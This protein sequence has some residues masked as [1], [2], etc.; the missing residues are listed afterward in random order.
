[1]F[2]TGTAMLLAGVVLVAALPGRR[3]FGTATV[4]PPVKPSPHPRD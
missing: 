4:T 2:W 1:M 3:R